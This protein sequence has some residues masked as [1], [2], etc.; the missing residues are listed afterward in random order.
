VRSILLALD[1]GL[2]VGCSKDHEVV[3]LA[4][5]VLFPINVCQSVR[6]EPFGVKDGIKHS[7]IAAF[8]RRA[9]G[10][11]VIGFVVVSIFYKVV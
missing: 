8:T 7:D 11:F 9:H 10:D 5:K 1:L 4:S 2:T 3:G 6:T